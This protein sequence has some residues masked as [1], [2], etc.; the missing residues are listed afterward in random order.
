MSLWSR[1]FGSGFDDEK[2]VSS[3]QTAISEDPMI[4]DPTKLVV[5]SEKGV[6]TLN[7]SVQKLLEKDH[8]EGAVRDALRYNGL[9]FEKI[10]NN[11][12]VKAVTAT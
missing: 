5:T 3:V 1:I 8:I 11:I 7:G 6:I 2:L 10:V 4:T 9:K 12:E